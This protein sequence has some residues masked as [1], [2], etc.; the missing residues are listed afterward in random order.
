VAGVALNGLPLV[1]QFFLGGLAG[2][3]VYWGVPTVW[4]GVGA[5]RA[6]PVQFRESL[7]QRDVARQELATQQQEA[8]Q[9]VEL[10]GKANGRIEE[11]EQKLDAQKGDMQTFLR[12]HARLQ[13][14]FGSNVTKLPPELVAARRIRTE[15][16]DALRKATT[17]A[18][19]AARLPDGQGLHYEKGFRFDMDAWKEYAADLAGF[20]AYDTA[21]AAYTELGR[22]NDVIGWRETGAKGLYGVSKEDD[23]PAVVTATDA[24]VKAL[25]DLVLETGAMRTPYE[26]LAE[27]LREG[28]ALSSKEPSEKLDQDVTQWTRSVVNLLKRNA[29]E[30]VGEFGSEEANFPAF[31]PTDQRF[32]W[33]GPNAHA[34]LR[35]KLSALEQITKDVRH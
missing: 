20:P 18:D 7:V 6:R 30:R 29:P 10:L 2:L 35:K 24:A 26:H 11:L 5:A 34:F 22:A 9:Y 8:D 12:E 14:Q 16:K 27:K 25:D 4:A 21:E 1:A 3:M 23:L 31:D 19:A 17:Y 13:G 28:F 32:Y 33:N 15:L